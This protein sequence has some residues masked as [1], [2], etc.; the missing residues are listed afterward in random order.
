MFNIFE[1]A[2]FRYDVEKTGECT[3]LKYGFFS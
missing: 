1:Q 2:C 3:G